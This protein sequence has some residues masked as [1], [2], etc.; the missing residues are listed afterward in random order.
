M[1]DELERE[2]IKNCSLALEL[3][4]FDLKDFL[5]SCINTANVEVRVRTKGN[6]KKKIRKELL[7][8]LEDEGTREIVKLISE[9]IVELR[10]EGKEKNEREKV[11]Y[12]Y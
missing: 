10:E 11:T 8:K 4:E 7:N 3:E 12:I 5:K 1:K 2:I 9:L 6:R